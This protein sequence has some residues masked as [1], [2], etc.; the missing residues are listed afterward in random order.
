MLANVLS[1]V[2]PVLFRGLERL[3]IA[4]NVPVLLFI[5]YKLFLRG[6]TGNMG[7]RGEGAAWTVSA[8][9]VTPGALCFLLATGLGIYIMFSA[10]RIGE[11]ND[12]KQNDPPP[13]SLEQTPGSGT[14]RPALSF[15]Q[16]TSESPASL[17]LSDRFLHA[18]LDGLLCL[19]K[20]SNMPE[21]RSAWEKHLKQL[22][23]NVEEWLHVSRL[24]LQALQ[25]SQEAHAT[26]QTYVVQYIPEERR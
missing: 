3:L 12:Q 7:I 16:P 6:V 4:A 22:P 1:Q 9:R 11:E 5:G 26:L 25:G 20:G 8:S 13:Q 24:Q 19:L 23:T 15:L 14:I 2:D 17:T 18:C 10:L 21:C